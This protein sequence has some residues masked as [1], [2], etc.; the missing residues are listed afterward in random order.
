MDFTPWQFKK[1]KFSDI[2]KIVASGEICPDYELECQLST[3]NLNERQAS[4]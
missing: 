4:R 3:E 1:Y 2:K